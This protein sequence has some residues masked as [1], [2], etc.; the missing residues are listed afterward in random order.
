MLLTSAAPAGILRAELLQPALYERPGR[1][2]H[3]GRAAGVVNVDTDLVEAHQGPE[4]H[5]LGQQDLDADLRQVLH[6]RTS[7]QA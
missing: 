7:V 3:R 6:R 5:S 2:A 4:A 1:I